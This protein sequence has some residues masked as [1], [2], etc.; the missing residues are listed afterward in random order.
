MDS[1]DDKPP[2]SLPGEEANK[3]LEE[4]VNEP[5]HTSIDKTEK[6]VQLKVSAVADYARYEVATKEIFFKST[7]MYTS[8]VHTF[9]LKNTSL[10]NI[11]YKSRI[12]KY[13]NEDH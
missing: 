12:I 1:K 5:D 4:A 6:N 11:N 9:D 10:I 7:L 2:P 8:R 13:E 3:S